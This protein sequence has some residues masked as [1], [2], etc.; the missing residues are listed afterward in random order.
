MQTTTETE[1]TRQTWQHW[2]S[3]NV[4][5]ALTWLE[6][7][8][9]AEHLTKTCTS[10]NADPQTIDFTSLLDATLDYYENL[11]ALDM[12]LKQLNANFD[13]AFV[14][15]GTE[16]LREKHQELMRRYRKLRQKILKM[17]RANQ[18]LRKRLKPKK[19][20]HRKK[21]KTAH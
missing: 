6:L 13:N 21:R 12:Q 17:K 20:K 18:R 11:N 3:H 10:L 4:K 8:K 5:P 14:E 19:P 16:K 1:L 15:I 7:H 9:L 2:K